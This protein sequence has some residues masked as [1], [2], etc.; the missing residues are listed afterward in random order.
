MR[1]MILD[2]Q[3]PLVLLVGASA[4]VHQNDLNSVQALLAHDWCNDFL[5]GI[6]RSKL[7]S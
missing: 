5:N 4:E 6:W 7:A 1:K 3:D 2:L